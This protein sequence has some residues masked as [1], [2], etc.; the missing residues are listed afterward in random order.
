[1]EE[2]AQLVPPRNPYLPQV[3]YADILC[4]NL[5]REVSCG[6][7]TCSPRIGKFGRTP[8]QVERFYADPPSHPLAHL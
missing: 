8:I 4:Q 1:M 5:R 6:T 3:A 2:T 7:S